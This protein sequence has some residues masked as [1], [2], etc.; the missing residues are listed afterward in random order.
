MLANREADM[1]D[2]ALKKFENTSINI[3]D[4]THHLGVVL[5]SIKDGENYVTKSEHLVR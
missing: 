5:G 1:K 2:L 3:I 4:G